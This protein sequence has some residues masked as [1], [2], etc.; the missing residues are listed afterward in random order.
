[1]IRLPKMIHFLRERYSKR[2]RHT[3]ICKVFHVNLLPAIQI[4]SRDPVTFKPED[5]T[6][7][8]EAFHAQEVSALK[9]QDSL[10][11][12]QLSSFNTLWDKYKEWQNTCDSYESTA[13]ILSLQSKR[14]QIITVIKELLDIAKTR[15]SY[16]Q[17][18]TLTAN[19]AVN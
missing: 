15:K 11:S 5:F 9:I 3:I 19:S 7:F 4:L 8:A 13:K 14:K 16:N 10:L 18:C 12:N 1:M 2:K 6:N 17:N